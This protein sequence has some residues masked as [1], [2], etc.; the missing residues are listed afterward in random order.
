ML[1]VVLLAFMELA[2]YIVPQFSDASYYCYEED[3]TCDTCYLHHK[4]VV[5]AGRI[6]EYEIAVSPVLTC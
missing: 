5:I 3:I 6:R 4:C 2:F 1:N